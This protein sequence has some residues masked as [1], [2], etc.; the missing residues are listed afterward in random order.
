MKSEMSKMEEENKSLLRDLGTRTGDGLLLNGLVSSLKS[1]VETL[2]G[3]LMSTQRAHKEKLESS[4]SK[5]DSQWEDKMKSL[6]DSQIRNLENAFITCRKAHGVEVA[7]LT[8]KFDCERKSLEDSM[9]RLSSNASADLE[10]AQSDLTHTAEIL[11]AEKDSHALSVAMLN[12][13]M[14]EERE[15]SEQRLGAELETLRAAAQAAAEQRE[16]L[17]CEGHDAVI[18]LMKDM[19]RKELGVSKSKYISSYLHSLHGSRLRF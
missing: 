5:L 1:Q 4:L 13:Q 3:E 6:G 12:Q 15:A 8:A 17:A 9:L 7:E 18:V 19:H 2:R 14:K 11:Q 10:R 16:R